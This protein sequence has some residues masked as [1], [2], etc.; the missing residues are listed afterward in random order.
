MAVTSPNKDAAENP[1]PSKGRMKKLRDGRNELGLVRREYWG[2]PE[3]HAEAAPLFKEV[4]KLKKKKP[5]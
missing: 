3:E 2:L 1:W 4:D 5:G